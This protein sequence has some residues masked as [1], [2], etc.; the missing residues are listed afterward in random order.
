MSGRAGAADSTN[1]EKHKGV[2][3]TLAITGGTIVD[4]T[5]AEPIGA[6]VAIDG[7]R[8]TAIGEVDGAGHREL[9]AD[10]RR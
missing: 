2:A 10:G 3:T 8:I 4:G 1:Q 7:D 9:D 5:G 6:D